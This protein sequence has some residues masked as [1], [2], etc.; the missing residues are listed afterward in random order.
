MRIDNLHDRTPEARRVSAELSEKTADLLS[1]AHK[2]LKAAEWERTD[3][4]RRSAMF[5]KVYQRGQREIYFTGWHGTGA[6]GTG[7]LKLIFG[8]GDNQPN[9]TGP[10]ELYAK[11]LHSLDIVYGSVEDAEKFMEVFKHYVLSLK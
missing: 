6:K 2:F 7:D 8:I 9:G 11:E 1:W 5:E 10:C 3:D 4:G